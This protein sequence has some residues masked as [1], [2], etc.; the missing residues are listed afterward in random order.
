VFLNGAWSGTVVP[1]V[2]PQPLPPHLPPVIVVP[3]VNPQ[4]LPPHSAPVSADATNFLHHPKPCILLPIDHPPVSADATI[5][6]EAGKYS[7]RSRF[8]RVRLR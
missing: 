3:A 4:P 8:R 1:A 6:L 7:A 2:N 5:F